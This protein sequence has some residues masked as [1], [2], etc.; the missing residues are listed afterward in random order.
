[1][2]KIFITLLMVFGLAQLMPVQATTG[3]KNAG[4]VVVAKLLTQKQNLPGSFANMTADDFLKLTPK[5]IKATTGKKLNLKEVVAL[6]AA[7]KMVKKQLK[8]SS[9]SAPG[10]EKGVYIILAILIPFVAVG[11]ATDWEGN[12]WLIALLLSLLCGIPGIIYALIKMKDYY[13]S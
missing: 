13:P 9:D 6:K 3:A 4:Q 11:L 2:R 12:D 7:Q 8:S 5:K 1:M 10:I